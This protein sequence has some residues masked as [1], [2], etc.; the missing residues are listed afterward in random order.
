MLSV[1]EPHT[2]AIR[3]GKIA[4]PT[5]FGNLVTIHEAE[6]Q[7]ISAYALHD[8][9]PADA[10]LWVPA[11]DR[12]GTIFGRAPALAVGDRGFLLRRE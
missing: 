9:R 11:L 10:S 2:A 4:K 12:H 7:I 6:G 8:G 3:K 5:E 1:F